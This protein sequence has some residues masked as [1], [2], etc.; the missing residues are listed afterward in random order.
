MKFKLMVTGLFTLLFFGSCISPNTDNDDVTDMIFV[1]GGT[2]TMGDMWGDGQSDE[3]PL[4]EVTLSDFY[5]AKYEVTQELYHDVMG[6][7][8]SEFLVNDYPVESIS[9]YDAVAFCNGLSDSADFD[10]VYTIDQT[11]VTADFS[12]NGY[13][14]P[15]EA[16]WEYAAR[17][18]GQDEWKWSGTGDSSALGDYAWFRDNSYEW[19]ETHAEGTNEV[20]TRQPNALGLYDMSGNVWEWCWDIF[21]AYTASSAVDPKGSSTGSE[22]VIRGGSWT[23]KDVECRNANRLSRS[24]SWINRNQ[25]FRVVRN[26]E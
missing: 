1:E 18:G 15:T 6:S 25:G 12:K 19:V 13:R 26:A 21:G 23:D 14:L 9:W 22:R 5:I 20:G 8:S 17:S 7:N 2:F 10:R 24:P 3:I 16:E 11:Q 4:H